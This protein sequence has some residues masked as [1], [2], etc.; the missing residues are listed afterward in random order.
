M[1][2]V[3]AWWG[4]YGAKSVCQCEYRNAS[5]SNQHRSRRAYVHAPRARKG[6]KTASYIVAR[7]HVGRRG[8]LQVEKL[9]A[10][11]CMS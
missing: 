10:G 3:G 7:L 4:R 8:G 6:V 2:Y 1:R 11:V 5:P 9:H